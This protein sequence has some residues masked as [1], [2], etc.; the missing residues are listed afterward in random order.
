MQKIYGYLAV[1]FAFFSAGILT[2]WKLMGEQVKVTVKRV[3]VKKNLGDTSVV[4]PIEIDSDT[5]PN[6]QER[7]AARKLKRKDRK[8]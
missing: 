7:K 3:K 2:M 4:V 5:K 8:N 6:R 1:G